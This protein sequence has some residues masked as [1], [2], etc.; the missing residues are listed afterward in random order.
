[1]EGEEWHG[2]EQREKHI[3]QERGLAQTHDKR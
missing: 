1:M 3:K 2:E